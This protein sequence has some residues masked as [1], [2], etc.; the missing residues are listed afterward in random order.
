MDI[1]TREAWGMP[2]P[3]GHPMPAPA[4]T[5][6][7]HHSV[8]TAT[9]RVAG[10]RTIANI[11]IN[12]FGRASYSYVVTLNGT[13]YE[14]QGFHVGAHTHGRNSTSLAVCFEGNYENLEPTDAQLRAVAA[15]YRHLVDVGFL[16][17]GATIEGHRDAPGAATACPGRRLYARL[18]D[19]RS[20]VHS[21]QDTEEDDV[22]KR[23]D[24]GNEV[25]VLQW[26]LN[27]E[28]PA[29][30]RTSDGRLLPDPRGAGL[31]YGLVVDGV[32]GPATE[33]YVRDFQARYGYA[34]TGIVNLPVY[35]RLFERLVQ[36]GV[37][38]GPVTPCSCNCSSE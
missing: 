7:V 21:E 37:L 12:R 32:F 2:G 27:Q 31:N 26:R 6:Y 34:G 30:P 25:A 16:R 35:M 22:L 17:R 3:L 28:H 8:T 20:R 23:G 14:M 18:P 10:V 15:L 1:V 29:H 4:S 5:L 38:H 9:D 11:G 24:A 13:V 19:I 33:A 36:R